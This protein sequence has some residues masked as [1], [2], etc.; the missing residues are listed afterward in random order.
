MA[1]WHRADRDCARWNLAPSETQ[2][3]RALFWELLITDCWQVGGFLSKRFLRGNLSTS[4]QSLATGR[5]PTFS[6]PFVDCEL[7]QDLEQTLAVDGTPQVS[8]A[9]S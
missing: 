8:C 7:P 9:Y 2:K 5:L 4:F 6:L 1:Q 3:R